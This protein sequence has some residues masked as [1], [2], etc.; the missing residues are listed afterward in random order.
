MRPLTTVLCLST[1]VLLFACSRPAGVRSMAPDEAYTLLVNRNWLD[2]MPETR[3]ERF[4]VLR[5][6]PQMNHSGVYQER[7]LYQG[8]FELFAF[9]HTGE[10]I[11][12]MLPHTGER[13]ATQYRID[14]LQPGEHGPFDLR[15]QLDRSPRGP[16]TY[17]G[18]R[19]ESQATDLDQSLQALLPR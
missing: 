4:H 10:Q 12:F 8:Q 5:F 7:T 14:Q 9:E 19:R 17:Y 16:A 3:S 13:R 1:V 2:R 11:R 15:L 18:F 6:I